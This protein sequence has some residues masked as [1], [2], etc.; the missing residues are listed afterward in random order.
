M[1]GFIKVTCEKCK[2]EQVIFENAATTVTCLVCSAVLAEPK[3]GR[4][5][6]KASAATPVK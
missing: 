1:A 4:A 2:N 6:I 5:N 3:G